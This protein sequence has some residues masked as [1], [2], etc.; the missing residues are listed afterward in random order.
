[1]RPLPAFKH[2]VADRVW[3]LQKMAE[4]VERYEMALLTA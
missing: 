3:T 1:L 2:G 4:L